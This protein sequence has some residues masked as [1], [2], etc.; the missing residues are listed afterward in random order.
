MRI[1]HETLGAAFDVVHVALMTNLL[2]VTG[3]LPLVAALFTTDPARSWPLL[4]LLAPPCLPAVCAAFAVLAG[5]SADRSTGVAATFRRS[6]LACWRRAT[7]LGALASAALVVLAV[8][9]RAAWGHPVGAVAV[10]VLA[11]G[12]LLV[13]ATLLLATV[14]L[15]ERPQVSLPRALKAS[16]YLAVRHWYLT[17]CSLGVLALLQALLAARPALALGL[18]AAPLLYVV[19]ANS[20]YTLRAALG[21]DVA[22]P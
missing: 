2:L 11:V 14:V 5:F 3:C 21:P 15:A 9:A 10:P 22:R 4:A 20:R 1:R 17:G 19:W 8:D 13:V 12:M 18:A 16:V 6:W 7:A